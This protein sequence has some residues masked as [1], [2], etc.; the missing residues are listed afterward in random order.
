MSYQTS[1]SILRES[2][3]VLR[4]DSEL[5]WFPVIST[6]ATIVLLALILGTGFLIPSIGDW[7]LGLLEAPLDGS[8]VS[9]SQVLAAI[10]GFLVYYL[11]YFVVIFCNTALVSCV[12]M[13]FEGGDPTVAD[14]LRIAGTR[15][16]QILA[17]TL[18]SA[19][20]G[21]VL[22]AIEQ[23]LSFVGR[24]IIKLIGVGWS[25]AT[26]FVVPILAAEGRGPIDSVKR[27]AQLLRASWGEGLIGNI[28][29]GL[30]SGFAFLVISA[31]VALMLWGSIA[32]ESTMMTAATVVFCIAAVVIMSTLSQIF[33]AG[34]YRFAT[35][36]EV[37]SGF[38][39]SSFQGAFTSKVEK[40]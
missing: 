25:I 36:G 23:R 22:S 19:G 32:L 28:G 17:W 29:L 39:S 33:L 21:A 3:S 11:L 16:P 35:T 2:W 9:S 37:A 7:A 34:L 8:L 40:E 14:G 1:M 12:L 30:I 4:Q 13:R 18:L 31:I 6:L 27:S 10:I 15:L 20:V 24:I 38:T 26:Y 5:I